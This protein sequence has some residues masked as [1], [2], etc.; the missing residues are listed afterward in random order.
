MRRWLVP[1]AF[2]LL[3]LAD[4]LSQASAA[5]MDPAVMTAM[6]EQSQKEKKGLTVFLPGHTLAIVVTAVHGTDSVE[7]RNQEYQRV[8]IRVDQILALAFQ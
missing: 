8:V 3:L 7:G 6:F 5:G 2:C 1:L 4:P